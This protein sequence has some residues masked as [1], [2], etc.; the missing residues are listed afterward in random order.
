MPSS[1]PKFT[2]S[3]LPPNPNDIKQI[4]SLLI[5][6]GLPAELIPKI[7]DYASYWP[8]C[9]CMSTRSLTLTANRRS[10]RLHYDN[11]W[12]GG[13]EEELE[14]EMCAMGSGLRDRN[15]EVWYLVTRPLGCG[16]GD[17]EGEE[18]KGKEKGKGKGNEVETD[19]EERVKEV[20]ANA[21]LEGSVE[22]GRIVG[23]WLR[24]VVVETLSQ[25]QG[26]STGSPAEAYGESSSSIYSFR[27]RCLGKG[28]K[29]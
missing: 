26:W 21:A 6:K 10:P 27:P 2:H 11:P 20:D 17:D 1:T 19:D 16:Y 4:S 23:G 3:H 5:Q 9:R 28:L 7:L 12:T 15:G 29:V 8:A 18:E 25:D 13:Q 22:D 24:K 14:R